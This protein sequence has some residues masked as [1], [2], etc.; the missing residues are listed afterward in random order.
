MT[1]F[2]DDVTSLIVE[3][4]EFVL[5]N[6]VEKVVTP[7]SDKTVKEVLEGRVTSAGPTRGGTK[8]QVRF[9][10]GAR[11]ASSCHDLAFLRY[12]DLSFLPTVTI[13]SAIRA[14]VMTAVVRSEATDAKLRYLMEEHLKSFLSK[15]P[16]DV[17]RRSRAKAGS[18]AYGTTFLSE[19]RR[20]S[21]DTTARVATKFVMS[22]PG[23]SEAV[24]EMTCKAAELIVSIPA[25]RFPESER[26]LKHDVAKRNLLK[27]MKVA[28]V[29]GV[30]DSE[31]ED[32]KNEA[33]VYQVMS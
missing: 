3:E 11:T 33:L 30:T 25:H 24:D 12:A 7:W 1:G 2:G 22:F 17:I 15:I 26:K 21:Y 20:L 32:I 28:L 14:N 8:V 16:D 27:A 9:R 4:S 10:L 29:A 23:V 13:V 6:L 31:L 5:P 18:A 19:V